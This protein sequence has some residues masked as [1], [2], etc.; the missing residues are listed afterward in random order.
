VYKV[1]LGGGWVKIFGC[2]DDCG[3]ELKVTVDEKKNYKVHVKMFDENWQLICEKEIDKQTMMVAAATKGSCD[4]MSINVADKTMSIANFKAPRAHIDVY[5][6]LADGSWTNVFSCND[7]CGKTASLGVEP[8]QKYHIH[9]KMF[10]RGWQLQCEKQ[11]DYT[12]G[13]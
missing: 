13:E 10:S 3:K 7:N 8:N 11:M 5:K 1:R 4:E 12:T 2:N 6:V 9:V